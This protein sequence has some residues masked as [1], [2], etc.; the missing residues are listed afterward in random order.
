MELLSGRSYAKRRGVSHTA[1]QKAIRT[2]RITTVAGKIDPA[3]ADREWAENTD[4]STSRNSVTGS[5]K[6]RRG[7]GG[8]SLPM[9]S[10][11]GSGGGNGTAQGT[12]YTRARAAREAALAQSAKLDLD[13]RLGVLCRT[14]EVRLRA[15]N[16]SRRTRDHLL[17]LPAR[18]A[19][20]LVAVEDGDVV[21]MERILTVEVERVC[22]ELAENESAKRG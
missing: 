5:P 6:L 4:P 11:D 2:G 13:E 12:G 10:G 21:E 15:F 16:L 1:V 7:K 9:G 22:K 20:L 19:P 3:I 17:A 14:D 18:A 8:P